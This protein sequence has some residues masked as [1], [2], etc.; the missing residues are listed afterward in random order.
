MKG[1]GQKGTQSP[2]FVPSNDMFRSVKS[3]KSG[4]QKFIHSFFPKK[5]SLRAP[6]PITENTINAGEPKNLEEVSDGIFN[7]FKKHM[8]Y[9]DG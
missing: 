5:E 6:E 1:R 8:G 2:Q 7:E 4:G 3:L 9:L